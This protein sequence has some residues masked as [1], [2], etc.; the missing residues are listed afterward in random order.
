MDHPF[1]KSSRCCAAN[2]KNQYNQNLSVFNIK[3]PC[4]SVLIRVC[5]NIREIRVIRVQNKYPCS[6]VLIRVLKIIREIR[7]I[8]VQNKIP[9]SSVKSVGVLFSVYIPSIFRG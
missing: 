8:R 3:N 2:N 7:V 5:Q 1:F 9:C 6:S 4:L